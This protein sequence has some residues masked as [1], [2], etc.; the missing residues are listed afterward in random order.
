MKSSYL[1][2]ILALTI[3]A[4]Q[5]EEKL[6]PGE[7]ESPYK[8]PQ[9]NTAA[10]DTIMSIHRKYGTY[11]LYRFSQGDYA[12]DY[13]I[14]RKDSA[15]NANPAY[16]DTTLNFFR[17]QLMA[18]YPDSFLRK[19]M[20][21]KVLLASHITIKSGVTDEFIGFSSTSSMVAIGWADSTLVHLT[22][23]ETKKL[24]G[25]LHHYYWERAYRTK[26]VEVPS[27]FSQAMPDYAKVT[28]QNR[29]QLG[30]VADI[31]L[32][33]VDLGQ[34]FLAYID[35]ITC[36][37]TSELEANY[38][39]PGIDTKGLIR[40]KYNAIITYYKTEYGVD[41]QAIGNLP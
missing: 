13:S 33:G 26:S 7:Y 5:K 23:L 27:A 3:V 10:D 28:L 30:V 34:D 31:G 20:P 32:Y 4:C 39:D 19:T 24:R 25:K 22:P 9:G 18:Q 36:N 16:I 2:L 17:N 8:L 15:F 14:V 6:T 35:M 37:S 21:V 11:I 29:Y 41:L 1:F 40:Q 12:Y 38:F